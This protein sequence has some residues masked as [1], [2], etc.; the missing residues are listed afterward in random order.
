MSKTMKLIRN[1]ILSVV[2]LGTIVAMVLVPVMSY[3][4]FN[5]QLQASQNGNGTNVPSTVKETSI[6][7]TLKDGVEYFNNNLAQVKPD[8]FD[9]IVTFSDGTT[10]ALTSEEYTVNVPDDFSRL[11][12]E[13]MVKYKGLQSVVDITLTPVVLSKIEI[14][15]NPYLIAYA[16]GATFNADGMVVSAV[17]N[18]GSKLVITD[19]V[20]DNTALATGQREVTVTYTL[21]NDTYTAKVPV[22]VSTTLNNGRVKALVAD[23]CVVKS[24]DAFSEASV[25]VRALYESGNRIVL[26]DG[27]YTLDMPSG[28]AQMGNQYSITAT[29]SAD[30]SMKVTMPVIVRT[31]NE[32]EDATIVGGGRMTEAEYTV[33]ADGSIVATGNSVSFAGGFQVGKT[34]ESSITFNVDSAVDCVATLRFRCSNGY[35]IKDPSG[36]YYMKPLQMNAVMRYSVNG[37]SVAMADDFMIKGTDIYEV[38]TDSESKK[39]APLYGI[40]NEY[41]IEGVILEAGANTVRLEFVS[42]GIMNHW[43]ESPSPNVDWVEFDATGDIEVP[44]IPE[45]DVPD[46]EPEPDD[47]PVTDHIIDVDQQAID[48]GTVTFTSGYLDGDSSKITTPGLGSEADGIKNGYGGTYVGNLNAV[49]GATMTFKVSMAEA[50]TVDMYFARATENKTTGGIF[51]IMINGVMVVDSLAATGSTGGWHTYVEMYAGQFDLKAGENVIVFEVIGQCGNFDYLNL[52]Y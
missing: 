12:G 39:Y 16:T 2:I 5:E 49:M 8:D 1:I 33:Q 31:H 43:N 21:G 52:V 14:T 19:Y 48:N 18:D 13:I 42:T 24:G 26:D 47:E 6:T 34:P 7:A 28:T 37:R 10:K 41:E 44:E 17:Y 3:A 22:S 25:S 29:Y 4:S 45:P 36:Y 32:T 27:A 20:C 35:L 9:V 51:K 15:E 40:Y 46:P 11:G 50:K 23:E 38:E 30:P